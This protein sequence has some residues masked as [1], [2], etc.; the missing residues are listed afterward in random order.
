MGIKF[1]SKT[2][3]FEAWFSKRP[4]KNVAPIRL[5]RKGI[6]SEREAKKVERDLIGE[7]QKRIDTDKVPSWEATVALY[8]EDCRYRGLSEKTINSTQ[9]CVSAHTADAWGKK[10]VDSITRDEVVALHKNAVGDKSQGHQKYMLKCFRLVFNFAL[11]QGYISRSPVPMMKFKDGS[12]IMPVLNTEQAK[13][14]LLQA[15]QLNSEW[16]Y[17]WVLALYTGMRNGELYA[18]TWENVS[19]N[20]NKI[21]VKEGWDSKNGFKPFTK[22]QWDRVVSIAPELLLTLKELKLKSKGDY[23]VLPRLTAWDR[24]CQAIELRRFLTGIALPEVRFHDLRASWAT[25]LLGSG[26]EAIKVMNMGGWKDYKTMMIYI[27]K[28]G[29]DIRGGT[30]VLKLHDAVERHGELLKLSIGSHS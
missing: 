12:K 1:N 5:A 22:S 4:A 21:Y 19:L 24:G 11:D 17:H 13:R 8:I 16:Y 20:E 18:L 23:F 10:S 25:M 26:V 2:N 9:M 28:A 15:R 29:I 6:K 3:T 7:V 30:D 27:R 14:L